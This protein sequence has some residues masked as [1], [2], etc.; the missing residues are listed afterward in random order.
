MNNL[1]IGECREKQK[2][3]KEQSH[4]QKQRILLSRQGLDE[5]EFLAIENRCLK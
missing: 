2:T 1:F 5:T 4:Y 3:I